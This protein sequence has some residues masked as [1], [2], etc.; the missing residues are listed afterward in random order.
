MNGSKSSLNEGIK[1]IN[2]HSSSKLTVFVIFQVINEHIIFP[3]VMIQH[4]KVIFKAKK[5]D[6][7]L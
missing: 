1:L 3:E 5:T 7:K 4:A 2:F 6:A